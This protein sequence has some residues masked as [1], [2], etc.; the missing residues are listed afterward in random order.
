MKGR[1]LDHTKA[2]VSVGALETLEDIRAVAPEWSDLLERALDAEPFL[3]PEWLLPWWDSFGVGQPRLITARCDGRLVGLAPLSITRQRFLGADR[4][5]ARLWGNEYC[6]RPNV[7]L[8]ASLAREAARALVQGFLT[9]A[10]AWQVARLGPLAVESATTRALVDA[11]ADAGLRSGIRLAHA[12]PYLPLPG[13]WEYLVGQLGG[14]FRETLRRKARKCERRGDVAVAFAGECGADADAAFAISERTWQ[15]AEGTGIGSTPELDRFF[16]GMA[17]GAAKRGWLDMAYLSVA[18]VPTSFEFN[19]RFRDKIYNL[20]L[21]YRDDQA[22]LSPG[23]VLKQHVLR[24]AIAGGVS[25]YDMLGA[26]ES[27]KL[28]W[29]NRVRQLG[30]LWVVRAGVVPRLAHIAYFRVRPFVAHHLPWALALKRRILGAL[31]RRTGA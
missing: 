10:P 5:V 1:S 22:D 11:L 9:A 7:V 21:G 25:E 28:H 19:L 31:R 4:R 13:S 3:S 12:S 23:M 14:S 29:T 6:P 26:A 17:D 18:G 2:G 8:D 27:Y 15:H 16:R 20:K 24:R 30:E